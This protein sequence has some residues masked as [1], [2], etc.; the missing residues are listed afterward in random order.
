MTY[1]ISVEMININS[2]Y[3]NYQNELGSLYTYIVL[4]ITFYCAIRIGKSCKR[5]EG[6]RF[7]KFKPKSH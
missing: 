6:K 4:N 2:Y 5:N 7:K 3:H 1:I